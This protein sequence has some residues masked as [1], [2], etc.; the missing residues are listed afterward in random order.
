MSS[1]PERFAV[2][3]FC[4]VC[5]N[6]KSIPS[7]YLSQTWVQKRQQLQQ[8]LI[9][10]AYSSDKL[11]WTKIPIIVRKTNNNCSANWN[12]YVH[13]YTSTQLL[14]GNWALM[15]LLSS[16]PTTCWAVFAELLSAH[17]RSDMSLLTHGTDCL[18]QF[19][20]VTVCV[21]LNLNLKG[22]YLNELSLTDCTH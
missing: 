8:W 11:P 17:M 16:L 15:S 7:I 14:M 2:F 20:V 6:G 13:A 22:I 19:A 12:Q 3:T 10:K 18:V 9:V 4:V 1:R 5:C 21:L